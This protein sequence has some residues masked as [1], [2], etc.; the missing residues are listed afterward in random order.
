MVSANATKKK[1]GTLASL[2]TL[3]GNLAIVVVLVVA[4]LAFVPSFIGYEYYDILTGSMEPEIPV[5][6]LAVVK[7]T[8]VSQISEGDVIAFHSVRDG[9]VIT[10]RVM[11]IDESHQE[12]I[13]RGDANP[14]DDME[15]IPFGN[16]IGKVQFHIAGIGP[17]ASWL[18]TLSGKVCLLIL[19]LAGALLSHLG[20]VLRK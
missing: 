1:G 2:C 5:G 9:S 20:G 4:V 8:D 3:I 14:E 12:L 17:L 15:P 10:H 6:S 16:L 13:T 19:L 18:L 7:N 11:Q